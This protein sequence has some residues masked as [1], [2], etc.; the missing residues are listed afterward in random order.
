M[1]F[2]TGDSFPLTLIVGC[3]Q[4]A[5]LLL[6]QFA[7]SLLHTHIVCWQFTTYSDSLLLA[8]GLLPTHIV[9][10]QFTTYSDSLLAVLYLSRDGTLN[11]S[12]QLDGSGVGGSHSLVVAD[13]KNLIFT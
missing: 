2:T 9:C 13:L 12:E 5:Y 7:G 6:I 10:W 3:L 8:G 1:L 11:M 4:A